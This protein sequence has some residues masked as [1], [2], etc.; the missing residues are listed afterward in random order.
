MNLKSIKDNL[1]VYI[2][3]IGAIVAISG[4]VTVYA[5]MPKDV[6]NLQKKNTEQDSKI[7]DT[8]N[9]VEK[10]ADSVDKYVALSAEQKIAQEKRE[11][12]ILKLIEQKKDK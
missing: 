2:G 3:L 6:E 1:A 9:K 11:D 7:S 8:N 10:L 12:L 5:K 4:A